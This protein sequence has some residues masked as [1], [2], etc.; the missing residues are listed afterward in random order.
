MIEDSEK[1]LAQD[2]GSIDCVDYVV[3]FDCR[4][5]KGGGS[6]GDNH[7]QWKN[8]LWCYYSRQFYCEWA[9][10]FLLGA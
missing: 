5:R 10:G 4:D 7:I 2:G 9:A 6:Y 1:L 8:N 3:V